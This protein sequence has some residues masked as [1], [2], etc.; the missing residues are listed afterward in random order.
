MQWFKNVVGKILWLLKKTGHYLNEK[1]FLFN[2]L[3][4]VLM[5]ISLCR[6]F[7][8][9]VTLMLQ[10][11]VPDYGFKDYMSRNA[12][13]LT[14]IIRYVLTCSVLFVLFVIVGVWKKSF[15]GKQSCEKKIRVSCLIVTLMLNVVITYYNSHA[16]TIIFLLLCFACSSAIL[17]PVIIASLMK[18]QRCFTIRKIE[19]H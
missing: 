19:K 12:F 17:A 18:S 10:P 3:L 1:Y 7:S 5:V 8:I 15:S 2:W 16:T 6:F 9:D 11:Y 4:M 14:E 13:K